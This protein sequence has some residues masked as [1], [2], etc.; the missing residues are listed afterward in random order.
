MKVDFPGFSGGDRTSIELPVAQREAIQ[1]LSVARKPIVMVNCSGSAIALEPET[2]NC[3]AILQ[4]WYPG[5]EG[6]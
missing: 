4:A 6:G 3:D 5:E 2:K 1:A